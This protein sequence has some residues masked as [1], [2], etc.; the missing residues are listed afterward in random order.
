[1]RTAILFVLLCLSVSTFADQTNFRNKLTSLLDMQAKAS[2]AIDSALQLLRDLKQANV[3][4]QAEADEVNRTTETELGK[5][6]ADLT[7][8]ADQNKASGDE[9]TTYRKHIESEIQVTQEYLTWI[10]NRRKEIFQKREDLRRQRCISNMMF[11]K[12]L[13]EHEEALKVITW[14]KEDV[15]GIIEGVS[16]DSLAQIKDSASRLQ[17][18]A[19]LFNEQAM[20]EFAQ[21]TAPVD[22]HSAEWDNKATDNGKDALSFDRMGAGTDERDVGAKLVEAIDKLKQHLQDSIED[23]EKNEIQ[24]AWDLAQWLQDSE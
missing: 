18:Y 4:A 10:N 12:S 6:I 21:L 20:N 22:P 23:L 7:F 17:A 3:D 5:Q 2:D 1:M 9:S 24:A 13:K 15:L 11:I 19:H 8:I 14:L 16:D